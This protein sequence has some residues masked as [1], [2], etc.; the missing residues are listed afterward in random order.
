MSTSLRLP[1]S[2]LLETSHRQ[3]VAHEVVESCVLGQDHLRDL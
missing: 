2:A 1:E 3:Q